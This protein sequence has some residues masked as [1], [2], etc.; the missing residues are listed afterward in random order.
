MTEIYTNL[1]DMQQYF[2]LPPPYTSITGEGEEAESR[3][4][5]VT[6]N[7]LWDPV[8]YAT[9]HSPERQ[10]GHTQAHQHEHTLSH[11]YFF[12]A[13][14]RIMA[15]EAGTNFSIRF[16]MQQGAGIRQNCPVSVYLSDR[17]LENSK[18]SNG[19]TL[20]GL[21]MGPNPRDM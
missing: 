6:Q 8:T 17:S 4:D 15:Q 9:S 14:A 18:K 21:L 5:A 19:D 16:I 20:A 11:T 13:S 3:G 12:I 1:K 2:P 7:Q 10:A